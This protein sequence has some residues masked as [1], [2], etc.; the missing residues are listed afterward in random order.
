MSCRTHNQVKKP[1]TR[2]QPRHWGRLLSLYLMTLSSAILP[3]ASA[4]SPGFE[5]YTD[6]GY[7]GSNRAGEDDK[8]PGKNTSAELNDLNL[9][10]AM[11]NA[12][13]TASTE[14]RW[15]FEL[16]LQAGEDAANQ[17]PAPPPAANTPLKYADEL[18]YL[19][20][21]NVS[22]LFGETG[23]VKVTGGLINSFLGYESYLAIDNPNYTRAYLTDSVPYFLWGGEVKWKVSQ[24]AELGFYLVSGYN[25]LADPN[26]APSYGLSGAFDITP[27]IT[28]TQNL[29]F[30]PD[31]VNTDIEFWRFHSNSIVE[32]RTSS[33]TIAGAVDIG[34]EKLED[35]PDEPDADWIGAAIWVDWA[36]TE[37]LNLAFR[38]EYQKDKT[39]TIS[40]A[41]R[42]ARAITGTIKYQWL[43]GNN[44][45]VT[46]LE[47]RY[48]KAGGADSGF[49]D[50]G[51]RLPSDQ[52]L[53]VAS[54]MWRF[55]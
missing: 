53:L 14:S 51:D 15:G 17:V 39:G 49:P 33:L 16:G 40:G 26:N 4:D 41:M 42:T 52:L 18:S 32:W 7:L 20:R 29:Y 55:N 35:L 22:Y 44:R 45:I 10:L 50:D 6:V 54:L 25:H 43:P 24:N 12:W 23:N 47:A 2:S 19:Y 9:H 28:F 8:W 37:K 27:D 21:A 3:T 1:T 46:M 36:V 38:P 48:D 5:L 31:Q 13:K 11:A 30:G 34:R